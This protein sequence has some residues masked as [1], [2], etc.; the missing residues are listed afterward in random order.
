M[1]VDGRDSREADDLAG[2]VSGLGP[3][4]VGLSLTMPLKEA[5]LERIEGLGCCGKA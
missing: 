3:D 5:V 2:F 1:S 4:W